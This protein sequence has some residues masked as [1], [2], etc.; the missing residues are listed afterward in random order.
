[1]DSES[2]YPALCILCDG[3]RH[4][5]R[6]QFVED[7]NS[8]RSEMNKRGV[9]F[10]SMTVLRID[11]AAMKALDSGSEMMLGEIQRVID[12]GETDP[13]MLSNVFESRVR[14]MASDLIGE[15]DSM[16]ASLDAGLNRDWRKATV[17]TALPQVLDRGASRIKISLA[18][19]K[20]AK[21]TTVSNHIHVGSVDGALVVGD[22][23]TTTVYRSSDSAALGP[24]IDALI[25]ALNQLNGLHPVQRADTVQVLQ[26]IKSESTKQRPNRIKLGG[27][28]SGISDV[29]GGLEAAP[30]AWKTVVDWFSSLAG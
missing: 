28:I 6:N 25:H 24:A 21:A 17:E 5:V 8:V 12:A 7:A 18:T 9:L 20:N 4:S 11:E 15:R 1:M 13:A 30:G 10:S 2:F 23:N 14:N 3:V 16:L 19:A 26:E 27:L 29:L 22:G